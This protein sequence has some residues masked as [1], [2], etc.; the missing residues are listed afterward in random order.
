MQ[1]V[2]IFNRNLVIF[3]VALA[4]INVAV[5]FYKSF[6]KSKQSSSTQINYKVK[7]MNLEKSESSVGMSVD[8]ISKANEMLEIF[9]KY[10]FSVDSFLKDESANLII[11]SSLPDDFMEIQSVNERKKLFIHTLL[12]II[13]AENLKILEDR[14]KI[15]DWWNESQGENFSRDFW[16]AW[17]FELSEKYDAE[18]SNLGNLLIKVDIIP[19]SMALAQAAIESGWGTSRYLREGN[20]VYGQYTFEKNK[21]ILPAE[22]DSSKKFFIRKFENLSESTKSYFK[23]INTHLAYEGLREE[24]KKLRMGGENLSGLRLSEYLTSYSERKQ[25]YVNDVKK[26]IESNNFMKFDNNSFIN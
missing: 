6:N 23:N 26:I 8:Y 10:N 19:I 1:T 12:P 9:N 3:L 7:T 14:K 15:L 22:R 13:Y 20:A 21:G 4:L 16:P 18:D 17:L 5:G 24:R 2:S 11:F 25:D